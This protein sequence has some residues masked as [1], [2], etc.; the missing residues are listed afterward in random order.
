MSY[1][2]KAVYSIFLSILVLLMKFFTV[3]L[4][5]FAQAEEE[6]LKF[7]EEHDAFQ[8]SLK[9]SNTRSEYVLVFLLMIYFLFLTCSYEMKD[10]KNFFV[11]FIMHMIF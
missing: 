6:T 3:E 5:N 8:L 11:V 2:A 7:W 10:G 1:S 4:F 9:F